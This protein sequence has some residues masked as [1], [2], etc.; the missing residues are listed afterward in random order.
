MRVWQGMKAGPVGVEFW[1]G[2]VVESVHRVHVAVVDGGGNLVAHAGDPDLVT[3]MRSAAKPF[4]AVPLVASGAADRYGLTPAEL[5]VACGSHAGEPM[6]VA[7]VDA[8]FAKAGLGADLLQCGTH[9][10]RNEA[11]KKA[12]AGARPTPR[13]HN[14]S[15]KHAGLMALQKHLGGDP[16]DYW[17]PD[18]VA[19]RA[20][21]DAVAECCGVD[22]RE[23]RVGTDGCSAPNFALPIRHAARAFA[24]F[25][26]PGAHVSKQTA[27][28]LQRLARAMM[29]H[30]EMVGGTGNL[31][32]DLMGASE[33]RLVTKTGAEAVQGVGD[34][35]SGMGLFLK[36]EDGHSRAVGP[37]TVELLR[38]LGWL[39]PRAFEVLGEWWMPRLTNF[40]KRPVGHAKPTV[41][42]EG[43]DE[44]S[45]SPTGGL[46]SSLRP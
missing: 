36:I 18:G 42:L 1:R 39:E 15:G 14:C 10:V 3:Y 40:S 20:V 34:L 31:D 38:Q 12:L 41:T 33:D 8:I 4:Q 35:G 5:A 7:A 29:R 19:Q 9:A 22:P 44:P 25:A 13:H 2:D 27:D 37:A 46:G 28:A 24:T 11:A 17:K 6:H 23:V 45:R 30:P 21:R 16:A 32:T 26:L 43:L